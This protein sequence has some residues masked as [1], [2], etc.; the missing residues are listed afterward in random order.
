MESV[1]AFPANRVLRRK[2][3]L[4]NWFHRQQSVRSVNYNTPALAVE[5]CAAAWKW[6]FMWSKNRCSGC[7]E[8]RWKLLANRNNTSASNRSADSGPVNPFDASVTTSLVTILF[9][10]FSKS[11]LTFQN[12]LLFDSIQNRKEFF[13][14]LLP[15]WSKVSRFSEIRY[16]LSNR[17]DRD[18]GLICAGSFWGGEK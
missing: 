7:R 5:W 11:Y 16:R 12:T 2:H 1:S 15:R 9:P 3:T 6:I 4:R 17:F 13:H 10:I 14:F 18:A 8:T